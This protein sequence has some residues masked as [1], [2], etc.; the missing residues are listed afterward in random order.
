MRTLI[1]VR[2]V[3][4]PADMGSAQEGLKSIGIA[5]LGKEKWEE[6][7]ARIAK[8]WNEAEKEIDELR[9]DWKKV[10][11][12]QDGLPAGG[13]VAMKI[14][15]TATG[16]GSRNYQIVK[17]LISRGAIIEATESSELLVTE[18]QLIKAFATATSDAEKEEAMQKYDAV[19]DKLMQARDKFM[20]NR[21]TETLKEG[22]TGILFIGAH[23]NVKEVLP[24]DIIIKALD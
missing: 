2:V 11:I 23:H 7:L 14:I 4:N 5:K 21:I 22:E 18:F 17:K 9:L 12:Y 20:A 3:H 1:L 24:K 8:F 6:N 13:D 15:N 16:Q 19:K 10:R